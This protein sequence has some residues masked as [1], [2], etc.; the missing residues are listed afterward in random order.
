MGGREVPVRP[1]HR[2]IG[3]RTRREAN[4]EHDKRRSASQPWRAWYKTT[5]WRA[6]RLA[7]F[8]RDLYTCRMCAKVTASPVCDHVTPHKGDPDLFF[9]AANLQ[10]LCAK[11]HDS[12]KQSQE[13]TGVVR[14][15]DADGRPLD[16]GHPWNR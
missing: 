14:G 2:P 5:Q 6:L 11:C 4:R 16:P 9:D 1:L 7:T 3:Q 13:R 10:T 8:T 12:A 15:C